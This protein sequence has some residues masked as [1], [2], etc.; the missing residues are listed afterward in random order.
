MNSEIYPP[1]EIKR[2]YA[3]RWGIETSFRNL[4]YTMGL[5]KFHSKKAVCIRQEIYARLIMYNFVGIITSHVIIKKKQRKHTYKANFSTAAHAC[6]LY[7]LGNTSP[8][9]LES[10]IASFLIPIR[11]DRHRKR[12][13]ILGSIHEFFYRIA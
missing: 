5:L 11:P 9:V 12:F 3:L 8:P 13:A 6:R 10:I 2:L 4:K 1:E 7:F